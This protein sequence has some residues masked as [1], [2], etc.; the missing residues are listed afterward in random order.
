MPSINANLPP[1]RNPSFAGHQTF[2]LRAGWLK[3]GLDAIEDDPQI[4]TR[5]DALV[6]LGVGKNMVSAIR[7]WLLATGLARVTG[8]DVLPRVWAEH[9]SPTMVSILTLKT[10]RLCGFYTGNYV[11]RE[12]TVSLGLGHSTFSVSGNGRAKNLSKI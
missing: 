10:R 8:R 9:Y 11:G 2:A 3:K 4:F 1:P 7:H 6:V 12:A 5:D